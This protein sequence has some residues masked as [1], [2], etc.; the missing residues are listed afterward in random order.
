MAETTG[1]EI[2]E[3]C[4]DCHGKGSVWEDDYENSSYVGHAGWRD[5]RSCNATGKA[6]IIGKEAAAIEHILDLRRRVAELEKENKCFLDQLKL[7]LVSK[8]SPYRKLVRSLRE[9]DQRKA[10]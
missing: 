3:D 8:K 5:C 7:N 1:D 2:L 9:T 6:I 4:Y 10:K